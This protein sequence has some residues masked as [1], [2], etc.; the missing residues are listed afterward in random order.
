MELSNYTMTVLKNFASINPNIVVN[1]GNVI[2][3]MS[4]ARNILASATVDEEFKSQFGIYDLPEFLS[5]LGLVDSPNIRFDEE[6]ATVGDTSG[7]TRI[8]YF[9]SDVDVL[10]SPTKMIAMPEPNVSFTLDQSTLNNLKRAASA[11]GHSQVSITASNGSIKLSI[12]DVDNDTSNTYSIEVDGQYD[13]ETFN[14]IISINNLKLIPA[15]YKVEISSKLIS[16]LTSTNLDKE[17]KY[18]IAL[19]KS[20]V[21]QG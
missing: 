21:Y 1:P 16:Q 3:T 20:S 5:V 18:W 9:F 19:E 13:V 17:L 7:R 10:T 14:F 2:T 11:L 15:D 6:F 8:K 12:V 4:E